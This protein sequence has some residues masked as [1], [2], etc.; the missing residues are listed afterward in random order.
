MCENLKEKLTEK[1]E[2]WG[3]DIE[4][5]DVMDFPKYD[6]RPYIKE[7]EHFYLY[8]YMPAEY[9]SIRN[10]ETQTIHLSPN[11]KLND[12]YEGLPILENPMD[13]NKFEQMKDLA[14]MT[15]FA[16]EKENVLMWSH[17]ADS[18]KGICIEYDLNQIDTD[19]YGILRHT[20]PVIYS[21]R[22]RL[23][24][25][26]DS[27]LSSYLE[28]KRAIAEE[29][30]YEG[31]EL[32]D[33]LI[34]L[35]LI[36]GDMWQY[37]KEWRVLY[38]IKNL[39]NADDKVL[40]NGNLWFPCISGIYLG[41]RINSEVKKHIIEICGRLTERGQE[42]KVYQAKPKDETYNITFEEVKF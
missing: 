24:R 36:K 17:Y 41:Y 2:Y 15:C 19:P 35:F 32:L 27:L 13:Y 22:R 40:Y 4:D 14:Y 20:F 9:Y 5:G 10:I 11:G 21:N 18:N 37:E 42:I 7:S 6:L 23:V 34:P 28:I 26:I 16:E 38:T 3:T 33:D 29:Y 31:E 30:V 12:F 25:D 39:Y 1:F 8:K